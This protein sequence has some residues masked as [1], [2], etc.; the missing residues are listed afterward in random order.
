MITGEE[1]MERLRGELP[2]WVEGIEVR[3]FV[4]SIGDDSLELRVLMRADHADQDRLYGKDEWDEAQRVRDAVEAV[5]QAE[6]PGR[7]A[8]ARFDVKRDRQTSRR[9]S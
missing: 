1:I 5:V 3:E 2:E 9:A 8:I 7:F 4:D 6:S